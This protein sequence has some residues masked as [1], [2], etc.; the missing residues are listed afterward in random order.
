MTWWVEG[1]KTWKSCGQEGLGVIREDRRG[2]NG[3]G[4]YVHVDV[5]EGNWRSRR[6]LEALG[7]M[8]SWGVR[9]ARV[10]LEGYQ[11]VGY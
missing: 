10:G 3:D 4:V 8:S 11:R 6:G 2:D 1:K 9:W 5:A 7:G